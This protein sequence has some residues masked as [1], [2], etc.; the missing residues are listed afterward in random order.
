LVV[1]EAVAKQAMT[2]GT[3]ETV[4]DSMLREQ[5]RAYVWEPLYQPYERIEPCAGPEKG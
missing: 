1:A 4:E 5:L 3:A 2:D